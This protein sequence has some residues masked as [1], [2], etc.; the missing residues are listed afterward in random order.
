MKKKLNFIGSSKE[1]LKG[2]PREATTTLGQDLTR[3]QY[4]NDPSDWK[5]ITSGLGKGV[6]GVKEVRTA[7]NDGWYRVAYVAS[8]GDKVHV[9]HAFQKKTN[10]TSKQDLAIITRNYRSI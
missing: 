9:L 10:E 4:G 6:V 1:K 8:I 3:I 2:F 5:A 7:S